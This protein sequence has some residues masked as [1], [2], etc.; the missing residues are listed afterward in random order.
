MRPASTDVPSSSSIP[1][2][3]SP[4][5]TAPTSESA[6]QNGTSSNSGSPNEEHT[7]SDGRILITLTANGSL[8]SQKVSAICRR[9]FQSHPHGLGYTWSRVPRDMQN[10]YW[11]EFQKKCYWDTNNMPRMLRRSMHG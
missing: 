2:I 4:R 5:S 6:S 8:D 1:L 7:T 11:K 3:P 9:C 10:V